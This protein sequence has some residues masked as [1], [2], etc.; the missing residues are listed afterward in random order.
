MRAWE[1]L[2]GVP[3]M[4][5]VEEGEKILGLRRAAACVLLEP[6]QAGRSWTESLWRLVLEPLAHSG[7]T[8][9]GSQRSPFFLENRASS[10]FS[11]SQV[12]R[13]IWR[14]TGKC[15]AA[16]SILR[17]QMMVG[18]NADLG[19]SQAA[20]RALELVL[21]DKKDADPGCSRDCVQLG[22][23]GCFEVTVGNEGVGIHGGQAGLASCGTACGQGLHFECRL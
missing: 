14:R 17:L 16:L 11:I 2:T 19:R 23:T 4:Q 3:K 8:Q 15:C 6:V 5:K 10:R 22:Y 7:S 18:K 13:R 12:G 9:W 21:L 20:D 1:P